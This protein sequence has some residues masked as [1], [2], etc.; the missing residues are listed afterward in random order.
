MNNICTTTL[1]NTDAGFDW[2]QLILFYYDA[3]QQ[4]GDMKL[5]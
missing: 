5:F 4:S 3:Q 2:I 1:K